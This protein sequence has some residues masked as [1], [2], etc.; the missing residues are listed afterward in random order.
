MK[1]Y[2]D[3]VMNISNVWHWMKK[4]GNGETETAGKQRNWPT[5]SVIDAN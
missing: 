2:R 3:V 4:Y 1:L 5:I